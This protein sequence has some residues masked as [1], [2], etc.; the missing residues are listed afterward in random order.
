MSVSYS[1]RYNIPSV[2]FVF[3]TC[4]LFNDVLSIVEICTARS[5]IS[6]VSLTFRLI[7]VYKVIYSL[8]GDLNFKPVV[9]TL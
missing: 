9:T 2:L 1:S 7:L 6:H 3:S 5:T 8:I 4:F